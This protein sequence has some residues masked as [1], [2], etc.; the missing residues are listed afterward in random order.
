MEVGLLVRGILMGLSI[1]APVGPI[2]I[3]V[4]RRTLSEGR[5]TGLVTGLGAATADAFYGSVGAF[6]LTFISGALLGGRVWLQALGGLFLCYLGFRTFTAMPAERAAA[7][8][9]ATL[10][11]SYVA[12]LLLTLTN[13]A[14]ILSFTAAFA[15][16]GLGNT[17]GEHGTAATLVGGVFIGSALWWLVLSAGINRARADL[18]RHAALDQ[19]CFGNGDYVLWGGGLDYY[20]LGQ[21]FFGSIWYTYYVNQCYGPARL[22]L[23]SSS[24]SRACRRYRRTQ[25]F[26]PRC[27]RKPSARPHLRSKSVWWNT[28]RLAAARREPAVTTAA[29][30]KAVSRGVDQ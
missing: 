14:T 1:A 8:T 3:L 11:R 4:I 6:G 2:G 26:A 10:L 29:L 13:P 24:L 17:N 30:Q 23:R 22:H 19:S 20:A 7:V 5:I 15:V 27:Q 28:N 16:L 9:G 21:A 18:A 12:T 25:V